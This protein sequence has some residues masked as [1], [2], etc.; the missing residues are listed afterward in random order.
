MLK[1][2]CRVEFQLSRTTHR[3]QRAIAIN[4]VIAW[5]IMVMTLVGRQI[6]DYEP[7]FMFADHEIDFLRTYARSYE[8]EMPDR[9]GARCAVSRISAVT[10]TASTT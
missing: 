10:R 4:A 1:S 7:Q 6:T 3:L 5:P 2:G 8:L 9:F